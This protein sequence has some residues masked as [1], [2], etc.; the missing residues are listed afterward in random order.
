MP[1]DALFDPAGRAAIVTGAHGAIGRAVVAELVAR[2]VTV[3]AF[4]QDPGVVDSAAALGA[5]GVV[6]DVADPAALESAVADAAARFDG[7]ELL[8]NNAGVNHRAAPFDVDLATWDRILAVNLTAY[9]VAARAVARD[10]VR[11][12]R[13]GAVVNVSSTAATT[14]LGR[15]NLAYGVSKAGVNQLTRELAVEFAPAQIRVNAVQPAQVATPAW[16]AVRAADATGAARYRRVTSGIP[17]GRLVRPDELVGPILFLLSPA[18]S[19]VTGTVLPVD[20]GNLAFNASGTSPHAGDSD[21]PE[22][23]LA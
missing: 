8:V 1:P 16:E 12:G 11:R 21:D 23:D 13:P 10:L 22:G 3:A 19:M 15:G 6:V 18:A 2:G 17:L 14:S 5:H 20:G 4:D 7:V 9:F